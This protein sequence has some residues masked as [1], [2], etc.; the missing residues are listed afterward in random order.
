MGDKQAK[1]T[2]PIR[3]PACTPKQPW[4]A[5]VFVLFCRLQRQR[6]GVATG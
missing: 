1:G 2:V 3:R 5:I 6:K 4:Q